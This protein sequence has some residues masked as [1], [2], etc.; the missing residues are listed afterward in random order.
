[1]VK[2]TLSSHH[3]LQASIERSSYHNSKLCLAP[4]FKPV[5]LIIIGL[6]VRATPSRKMGATSSVQQN[7]KIADGTPRRLCVSHSPSMG[8]IFAG[9]GLVISGRLAKRFG[10]RTQNCCVELL[11]L[12][13]H[14][15][16]IDDVVSLCGSCKNNALPLPP[17]EKPRLLAILSLRARKNLSFQ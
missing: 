9:R 2:G 6:P 16:I 1:M 5:K 17:E 11:A 8:P 7:A 12:C 4:Q 13:L 10:S 14:R 15:M 3:W